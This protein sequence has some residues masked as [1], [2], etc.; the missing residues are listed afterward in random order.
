MIHISWLI[1]TLSFQ[2]LEEK[3]IVF[4]KKELKEL[5]EDLRTESSRASERRSHEAEVQGSEEAAQRQTD[6][7]GFLK[8]TLSF[9]RQMKQDPLADAL[10]S[11]KHVQFLRAQRKCTLVGFRERR[12]LHQGCGEPFC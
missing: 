12:A 4:V 10:Q 9:L 7:E 1:Y 8:I 5:Q 3:I 6:R 2:L 11:R